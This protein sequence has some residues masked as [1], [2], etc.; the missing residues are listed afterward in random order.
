MRIINTFLRPL[1]YFIVRSGRF[2]H[3]ASL[4][5]TRSQGQRL[6]EGSAVL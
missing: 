1:F 2:T 3:D 4:T 5:Y 6:A